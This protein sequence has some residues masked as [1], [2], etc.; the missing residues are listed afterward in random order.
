MMGDDL[1]DFLRLSGRAAGS[2][3]VAGSG[4]SSALPMFSLL[5]GAKNFLF[6]AGG[7]D[8]PFSLWMQEMPV[9]R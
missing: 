3:L 7:A 4:C 2:L 9:L 1:S 5:S 6:D 8:F